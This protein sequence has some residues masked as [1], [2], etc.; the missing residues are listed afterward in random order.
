MTREDGLKPIAFRID[1]KIAEKFDRFCSKHP[2]D[3]KQWIYEFALDYVSSMKE[4]DYR[5]L[6]EPF[7]QLRS[8]RKREIKLQ[9]SE[10]KSKK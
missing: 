10:K 1:P 9:I 4:S 8:V 7:Y 5:R 2:G 3:P 6:F